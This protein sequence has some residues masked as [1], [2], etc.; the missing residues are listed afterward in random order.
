MPVRVRLCV[1]WDVCGSVH[2]SVTL[3]RNEV[4]TLIELGDGGAAGAVLL[5]QQLVLLVELIKVL[6]HVAQLVVKR[7]DVTEARVSKVCG[8]RVSCVSLV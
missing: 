8:V 7:R 6:R 3:A 1:R 4:R 2:A 5:L